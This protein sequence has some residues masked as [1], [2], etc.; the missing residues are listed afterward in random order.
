MDA[1]GQWI[2]SQLDVVAVRGW[3]DPAGRALLEHLRRAVVRPVVRRAGLRG[4]AA[5]HALASGWQ[6]AWD[7]L[8]RPSARTSANPAG[9]VWVAVRRAVWAEVVAGGSVE[10]CVSLDATDARGG[11]PPGALPVREAARL[12]P[13]LERLVGALVEE[14]WPDSQV[15][16]AVVI[17]ADGARSG[18]AGGAP[19]THWRWA[20][21]RLGLAPWQAS[22]LAG[23]LLGGAGFS[24]VLALMVEHGPGV[25][26]DS[27]I[28]A[29][30]ASTRAR[31]A[32]SPRLLLTGWIPRWV[33]PDAAPDA[34]PDA[35]RATPESS[36]LR[37][38]NLLPKLPLARGDS[39]PPSVGA[40]IGAGGHGG[41]GA[42]RVPVA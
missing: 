28:R 4:A 32:A 30:L 16:D 37:T 34:A 26:D 11:V 42:R 14:G 19:M 3:D 36:A 12:G 20:A 38:M 2:H 9:M 21:L 33:S 10:R 29:A 13:T 18:D 8:R 6:A 7:A 1:E 31:W 39:R 5:D 41:G 17:L 25:L 27:A 15:R 23:I 24:G 40:A 35:V 22:R